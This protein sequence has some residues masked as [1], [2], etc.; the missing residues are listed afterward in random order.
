MRTI[1]TLLRDARAGGVDRLDAQWL[2]A[3][4][5][6]RSPA[7]LIAHDDQAPPPEVADAFDAGWRRR[8]AGEPLA[9]VLGHWRF[10]GL[11][12][13]VSP[14]VLLPRPETGVLVAWARR[15]LAA[16]APGPRRTD[17]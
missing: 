5:L 12:L 2:L 9:Y 16:R 15:C 4:L 6:G 13:A 3:E 8:A 11:R 10:R 14:A 17:R 1:A 7:W